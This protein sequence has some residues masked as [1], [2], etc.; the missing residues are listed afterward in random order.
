MVYTKF[1][2]DLQR[3]VVDYVSI[4]QRGD[5]Y[6]QSSTH[7]VSDTSNSISKKNLVQSRANKANKPSGQYIA[8]DSKFSHRTG[9]TV[10]LGYDESI[11]RTIDS[12]IDPDWPEI[13]RQ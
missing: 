8:V 1:D 5:N 2:N 3:S 7:R 13:A 10:N 9:N 11:S 12:S 4:S 6:R